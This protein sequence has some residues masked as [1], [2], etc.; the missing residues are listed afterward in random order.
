[1][2][3]LRSILIPL[4]LATAALAACSDSSADPDARSTAPCG[5]CGADEICT[6][7]FGGGCNRITAICRPKTA[8][9]T[10]ASCTGAC[11]VALCP[12]GGT[13][14]GFYTCASSCPN[15]S[16]GAFHCYGP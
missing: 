1:M 6:E 13:D 14:A 11:E 16:A 10:S 15:E 7:T 8:T 2:L 3:P 4:T 9:C 12:N 5:G